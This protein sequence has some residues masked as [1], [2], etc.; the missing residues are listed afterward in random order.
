[1]LNERNGERISCTYDNYF[2]NHLIKIYNLIDQIFIFDNPI[3]TINNVKSQQ[4]LPKINQFH[5]IYQSN[6]QSI[7]L[8]ELTPLISSKISSKLQLKQDQNIHSQSYNQKTFNYQIIENNSIKQEKYCFSFAFNKNCSTV[9]VGC[10]NQIIIYEFKYD[11][12]KQIQVLDL[13]PGCVNTLNFMKNSDQFISGDDNGNISIWS[14]NNNNSWVCSQTIKGHNYSITCLIVNKIEDLIIS[15]S[16]DRT[17]QFRVKQNEWIC[18]QTITE[19]QNFVYSLSLNDQQNQV[20]SCGRD[21]LILLIE[22][23]EQNKNWIVVQK[24]YVDCYGHRLGFI[25]NN[26][27]SFKPKESNSMHV[28][29]KNSVNKQFIKT[30]E[31]IPNQGNDGRNLFPQQYIK[32]KQLLLNR[33]N[34]YINCIRIIQN[35]EFKLEQIIQFGTNSI[36]GSLSDDGNSLVTWDDLSKEIQIRKY[37]EQ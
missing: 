22:Y 9:A 5:I 24:I 2:S 25:N 18:S 36:F 19:H 12:F 13:L 17:I 32:L 16:Y 28:Y 15:G 23:S 3:N 27:F 10:I 37:T 6:F 31:V 4:S 20:I 30:K 8:S 7:I 29:E 21:K 35:G 33:H 26:I 11:M 14:I 34:K 1:M